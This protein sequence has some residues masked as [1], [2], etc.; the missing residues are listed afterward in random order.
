MLFTNKIILQHIRKSDQATLDTLTTMH[1]KKDSIIF[2]YYLVIVGKAPIQILSCTILSYK[3][4]YTR[5]S[6]SSRTNYEKLD[7]YGFSLLDD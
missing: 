6:E 4:L 3:N 1:F 7:P 2:S 5:D